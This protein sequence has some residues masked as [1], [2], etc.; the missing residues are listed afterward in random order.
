MDNTNSPTSF[1]GFKPAGQTVIAFRCDEDMEH[2]LQ[3]L[4]RSSF[5]E[6]S[7]TQYTPDE[8]ITQVGDDTHNASPLA[9]LGFE[10]TISTA[11][12]VLAREGCSFL[13]VDAPK[14]EQAEHVALVAKA[15]NAA[16]AQHYGHVI[17]EALAG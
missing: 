16:A 1:G 5:P 15:C 11:H 9:P 10:L 7:L 4:R 14:T 17:T 6:T 3:S 13:V 8:M 2:A 12:R